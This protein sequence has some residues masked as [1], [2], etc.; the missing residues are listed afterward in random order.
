[1][2]EGIKER[3]GSLSVFSRLKLQVSHG[4]I[5]AF[6]ALITILFVAFTV[7]ILPLRWENLS[8]GTSFL[9]EFDP[10]YQFSIT[11]HMV[12]NGLLS[13]Y[14]PTHWINTL[15][16]YP[17]GLDMY[18]SLPGLPMSAA[19]VYEVI[20]LFGAKIDLMTFCAIFPALVAVVSCTILY[21]IGKDMGGKA[22]GLFAALF[23]AMAPS[24]L[25]RSSL[26]FFDTEVPG[27]L[28]LVLF[29]FLFLRPLTATG[30]CVH[31]YYIR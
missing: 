17:D 13:P 3:L 25:Q 5:L 19:V 11:Q 30:P 31:P 24:F 16:W 22:V 28:G 26:G 2:G 29:I 15:K 12:T 8:G 14:W 1:M 4:S 9:N 21:L 10:Y 20:S 23:L 6:A 18:N 27:V 7:R